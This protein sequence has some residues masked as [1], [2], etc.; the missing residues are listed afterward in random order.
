MSKVNSIGW[1]ECEGTVVLRSPSRGARE[2]LRSPAM[3]RSMWVVDGL[4]SVLLKNKII[5]DLNI[6]HIINSGITQLSVL[7]DLIGINTKTKP[8][9]ITNIMR[10]QDA[11]CPEH[12][13]KDFT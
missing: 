8:T 4:S 12:Y 13:R 10:S 2:L 1:L 9:F 6:V 3:E 7:L 11:R 5:E